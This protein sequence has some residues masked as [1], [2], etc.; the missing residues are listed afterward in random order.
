MAGKRTKTTQ[1]KVNR[2]AKTGRFVTRKYAQNHP[3]TIVT[4]TVKK[5]K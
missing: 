4:E 3:S 2:S 5:K 1:T